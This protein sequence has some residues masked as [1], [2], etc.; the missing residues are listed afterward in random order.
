MWALAQRFA[1]VCVDIDCLVTRRR[2]LHAD[3]LIDLRCNFVAED[4]QPGQSKNSASDG[5][6]LVQGTL[7]LDTVE[8]L[9]TP[10]ILDSFAI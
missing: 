6:E 8:I 4:N 10:D 3:P 5:F 7:F 1:A 9:D 2:F